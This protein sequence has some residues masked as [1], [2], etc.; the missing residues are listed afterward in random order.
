[1]R[2]GKLTKHSSELGVD[3]LVEI[4]EGISYDKRETSVQS[5][6]LIIIIDK[7]TNML[8]PHVYADQWCILTKL[9]I[10]HRFYLD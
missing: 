7:N 4:A 2:N 10:M 9:K 8:N 1:M 6:P 3:E 5:L